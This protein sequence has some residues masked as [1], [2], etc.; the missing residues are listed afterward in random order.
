LELTL[1]GSP[2]NT[3]LQVDLIGAD[4]RVLRTRTAVP[5]GGRWNGDL[6]LSG[7]APAVY[8]AR[9]GDASF[10]RVQRIVIAR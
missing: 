8:F 6:D 1:V 7:L 4:G 5:S 2:S 10:Q 9:V 3:P